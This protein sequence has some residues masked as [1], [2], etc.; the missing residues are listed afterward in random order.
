M[1]THYSLTHK[2]LN[3]WYDFSKDYIALE[4]VG[5]HE[6]VGILDSVALTPEILAELE[7]HGPESEF[8]KA[9]QVCPS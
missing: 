8:F 7:E 3:V 5:T 1:R 9:W 4:H 6:I 2:G